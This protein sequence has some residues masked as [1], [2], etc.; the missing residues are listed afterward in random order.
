MSLPSDDSLMLKDVSMSL[1][2]LQL[3][4]DCEVS[5]VALC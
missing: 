3:E 1:Q 4:Q 5:C 2:E